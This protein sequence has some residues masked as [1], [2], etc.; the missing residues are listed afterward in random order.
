MKTW[1][2][3]NNTE[4]LSADE[5][6]SLRHGQKYLFGM[7][8]GKRISRTPK[9]TKKYPVMAQVNHGRWIVECEHCHSAELLDSSLTFFCSECQN[10]ATGGRYRPVLVPGQRK[11]IEEVLLLRPSAKNQSWAP[12]ESV[13]KLEAENLENGLPIYNLEVL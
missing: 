6:I 13:K 3:E 2:S 12:Q 9:K 1:D 10:K 11:R 4:S 7:K 8:I 5:I